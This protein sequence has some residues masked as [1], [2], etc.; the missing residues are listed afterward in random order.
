MK[1]KNPVFEQYNTSYEMGQNKCRT[2]NP[3]TP[4]LHFSQTDEIFLGPPKD[5][6]TTFFGPLCTNCRKPLKQTPKNSSLTNLFRWTV[7]ISNPI[8]IRHLQ[9]EGIHAGHMQLFWI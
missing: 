6:C 8:S 5:F 9:I 3:F 2:K 4:L 1:I 7:T